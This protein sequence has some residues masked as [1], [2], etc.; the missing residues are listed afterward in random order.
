MVSF[1]LLQKGLLY[2]WRAKKMVK[3][4]GERLPSPP[5][6]GSGT[7]RPRGTLSRPYEK[8][9]HRENLRGEC[10]VKLHWTHA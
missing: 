10:C 5:A 8:N 7:E 3:I 6:P 2:A 4:R 1:C 9:F